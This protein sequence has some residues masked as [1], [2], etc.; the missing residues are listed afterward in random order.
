LVIGEAA[1]QL[2]AAH[3]VPSPLEDRCGRPAREVALDR[4]DEPRQVPIDD[5]RLQRQG[6]RR[7]D[8]TVA[9]PRR[10][11]EGRHQV[12]ERLAGPRPRL[13]QQVTAAVQG[14]RDGGGHR[15][16]PLALRTAHGGDSGLEQ[17]AHPAH[18]AE[19][20]ESSGSWT[21]ASVPAYMSGWTYG[22]SSAASASPTRACRS[23]PS[24]RKRSSSTT[25]SS[26][27]LLERSPRSNG[28]RTASSR[29]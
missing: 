22:S 26:W 2:V 11:V 25:P 23:V 24:G 18:P 19:S 6:R 4:P 8:D 7:D 14:T 5:L 28:T 16:L 29:A 20:C 12:G 13:D 27:I 1:V 10:V 3:V 9:G 17:R 21:G 15:R